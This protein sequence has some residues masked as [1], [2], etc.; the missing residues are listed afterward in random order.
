MAGSYSQGLSFAKLE[1]VIYSMHNLLSCHLKASVHCK[2]CMW[3]I[4]YCLTTVVK[5]A[6]SDALRT[7]KGINC[8][9]CEYISG[10]DIST[11]E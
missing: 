8:H 5:L 4:P 1:M 6:Y 11:C 7:G 9:Y 2:Y 10:A 3:V